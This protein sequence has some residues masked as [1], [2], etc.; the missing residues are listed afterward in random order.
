MIHNEGPGW[1]LQ[2]DPSKQK[3]SILIG[4]ENWAV[5]LSEKEWDCLCPVVFELIDQY[6]EL[7][8]QLMP[9]EKIFL[10][11]E[12]SPWWACINGTKE[13][14]SLKLILSGEDVEGRGL[15]V[16][17]P[18]YTASVIVSAMRTMWDCK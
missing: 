12:R 17:W 7:Q 16:F 10:E 2:K 5:E 14:W 1:R 11:I 15:E 3:Y 9:E 13:N 8:K 4:G 18:V 6:E